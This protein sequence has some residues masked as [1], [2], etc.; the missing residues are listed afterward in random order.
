MPP[1]ARVNGHDGVERVGLAGQ[2][3]FGFQ[4]FGEGGEVFDGGFEFAEDV[5]AL[6]GQLEVR[7]NVIR[8][9]DK[10]FVAGDLAFQALALSHQRLAGRWISPQRRIG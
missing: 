10:F 9:A 5:F 1:A 3:G 8:A 7:V 6:A 2:H 4:V